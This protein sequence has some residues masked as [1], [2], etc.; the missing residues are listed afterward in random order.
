[1]PGDHGQDGGRRPQGEPRPRPDFLPPEPPEP[2]EPVEPVEAP[3]AAAP[4]TRASA[5][6]AWAAAR[7]LTAV[8][9]LVSPFLPWA[10]MRIRLEGF[11][12]ALDHDLVSVE[13]VNLDGTGQVVPVLAVVAIVMLGWGLWA[14]DPRIGALAAVPAALSLLACLIFVLRLERI[15]TEYGLTRRW[16]AGLELTADYGWYL[17]LAAALLL[18]G[19]ALARR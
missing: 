4:R 18:T 2:V 14:A 3:G 16:S 6:P 11:G 8:I 17:S 15:R 1:M 13:G 10:R 19:L 9:L 5:A 12:A 7:L